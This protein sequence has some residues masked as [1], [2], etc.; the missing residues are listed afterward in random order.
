MKHKTTEA[1][2]EG[3]QPNKN[4]ENPA[5]VMV[6]YDNDSATMSEQP[7]ACESSTRG[8]YV[9]VEN[10]REQDQHWGAHGRSKQNSQQAQPQEE[11]GSL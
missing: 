5:S 11:Q 4:I 6:K 10:S 3:V 1:E 8:Q 7:R 2:E 9:H